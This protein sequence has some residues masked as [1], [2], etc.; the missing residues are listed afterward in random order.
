MAFINKYKLVSGGSAYNL[1]IGFNPDTVEVWNYTEWET[2]TKVVKSYWHKGMTTDYAINE[3]CEDT[4]ANRSISTSNGFTVGTGASFS[5]A[6]LTVSGI[7]AAN[8]PVVTVGSTSTM[9]TGDVVRI[10]G[11]VGMTEVNNNDYKATV[12]NS[13]TFSLQNM[14]GE[15]VDGTGFTSYSSGGYV[16]DLSINVSDSGS[17]YITLGTDVVGADSDVLYVVAT[18]ADKQIDLGDIGA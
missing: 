18:Q 16:S 4:G 17:Y 5:G 11:V 6:V 2:D 13:T 10:H 9:T 1:A 7:T 14:D 3:I 15:N 12:I 8:P